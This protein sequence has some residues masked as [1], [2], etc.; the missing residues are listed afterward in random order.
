MN[1]VKNHIDVQKVRD[2]ILG[3]IDSSNSEFH[4]YE[5][6]K[7]RFLNS[8]DESKDC[9]LF[10]QKFRHAR[11]KNQTCTSEKACETN[12]N[13]LI[14]KCKNVQKMLED[15]KMEN[16]KKSIGKES[17]PM[18]RYANLSKRLA[19]K[20]ESVQKVE[21]FL[22]SQENNDVNNMSSSRS[23]HIKL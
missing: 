12:K 16:R 6:R 19:N 5:K 4:S 23:N 7:M 2:A 18:N 14:E 22:S 9:D 1:S 11:F 15:T 3:S 21:V 8:L 10:K 20:N 17:R 13:D